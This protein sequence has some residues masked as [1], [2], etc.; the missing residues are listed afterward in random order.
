MAERDSIIFQGGGEHAKVVLDCLLSQG[1][2][3]IG[4]FDPKYSGDLYGIPQCGVYDPSFSPRSK[5][6]VAIG[7]N[8]LRKKVVA[9]TK[10]DFT[11]AIHP[12]AIISTKSTMGKGNMVL[13]G[14]IIQTQ[15]SIGN[16]VII[17]TGARVDHECMIAD[18]VHVAPG[19]V[20]SGT[21]SVGEGAFIG[22]GATVINGR[23][24]GAWAVIGAGAVVI[25]DI[26]DFAV[27][28]GNPARII[29]YN[30]P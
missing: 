4:L 17:N 20:L 10:H 29:K 13:H 8:A 24:I 2:E 22:A 25:R 21:V 26:P 11:N 19:V 28:V 12:S 27:V 1:V 9:N 16:H 3:V 14:A 5:V 15:A 6:I 7:D 30:N 23:K 18:Y